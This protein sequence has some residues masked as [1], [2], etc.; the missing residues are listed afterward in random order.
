LREAVG[1]E[2][3]ADDG[4]RMCQLLAVLSVA[5]LSKSAEPLRAMGMRNDGTG[6]NNFSSFAPGVASG[7]DLL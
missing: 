4:E 3:A 6:A 2:I 7:T 5:S 1:R